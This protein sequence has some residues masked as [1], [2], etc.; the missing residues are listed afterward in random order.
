MS[1]AG[2]HD[3]R[4]TIPWPIPNAPALIGLAL[5]LQNLAVPATLP[6]RLTN[7]MFATLQ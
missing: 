3:P 1:P 6:P 4:A 2:S 7:G 5:W